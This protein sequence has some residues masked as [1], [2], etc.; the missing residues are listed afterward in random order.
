M[1]I[2][3]ID[4]WLDNEY[5]CSYTRL[6]ELRDFLIDRNMKY[7]DELDKYKNIVDELEK[8]LNY[9]INKSTE[10]MNRFIGEEQGNYS[11]HYY[12]A[13]WQ[14]EKAIGYLDKLKELKG[15]DE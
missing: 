5:G 12:R 7:Q 2:E 11:V 6:K 3:E 4:K 8:F 10:Y 15:S 14:K 1:N 13:E 9:D